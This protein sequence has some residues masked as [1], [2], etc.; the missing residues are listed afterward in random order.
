M[1]I[2]KD[3]LK[4]IKE[5]GTFYHQANW[6]SSIFHISWHFTNFN[7]ILSNLF[8]LP[9]S[10]FNFIKHLFLAVSYRYGWSSLWS[11]EFQIAHDELFTK[12]N[13]RCPNKR[14]VCA[15]WQG[16]IGCANDSTYS[17]YR[18]HNFLILT[19]S[20]AYR[21]VNSNFTDSLLFN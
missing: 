14:Y 2:H 1:V 12:S 13:S 20:Q 16:I 11:R 15:Y 9:P 10:L 17:F 8:L 3:L 19:C 18:S 5:H 7:W 6:M 4:E 21:F